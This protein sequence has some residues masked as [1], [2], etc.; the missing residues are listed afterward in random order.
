MRAR[1]GFEVVLGVRCGVWADGVRVENTHMAGKYERR[2]RALQAKGFSRAAAHNALR[3]GRES[4][5]AHR[6]SVRRLIEDLIKLAAARRVEE[7]AMAPRRPGSHLVD[8][9]TLVAEVARRHRDGP[10]PGE[11]ALRDALVE[12]P[13]PILRK[14]EA[15]M[16]AGS[17]DEDPLL[18]HRH[19]PIDDALITAHVIA[20]KMPLDEYLREGLR[21]VREQDIDLEVP[22]PLARYSPKEISMALYEAHARPAKGAIIQTTPEDS[23]RSVLAHARASLPLHD[24]ERWRMRAT[25]GEPGRTNGPESTI[26]ILIE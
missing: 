23:L 19:L 25:W 14:I 17:T 11:K 18:H 16:Y 21:I 1:T 3:S 12:L 4:A 22:W 10:L 15:I 24:S 13:Y 20:S 26:V 8:G 6:P 5:H 2:L 7:D 9:A